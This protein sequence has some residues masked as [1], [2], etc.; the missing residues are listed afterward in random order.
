V[1]CAIHHKSWVLELLQLKLW[2]QQAMTN[3]AQ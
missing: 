2:L 1:L 3:F